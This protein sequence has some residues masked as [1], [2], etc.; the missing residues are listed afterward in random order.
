MSRNLLILGNG[1]DLAFGYRTSYSDFATVGFSRYCTELLGTDFWPFNGS[2]SKIFTEETLFSHFKN[3]KDT[4]ISADGSVGWI[5]LESELLNYAKSKSRS[6][7]S[8]ELIAYDKACFEWLRNNLWYF[9]RR[10]VPHERKRDFQIHPSVLRLFEAIRTNGRFNKVITFNYS[11]P[12]YTLNQFCS[13]END[14]MPDV[15]YIHGNVGGASPSDSNI[16]IGI[17]EDHDI[18]REYRFLYK[19]TQVQPHSFTKNLQESDT[20]IIYGL[21][22]G[23]IDREYFEP[24]F[25]D[26]IKSE[27]KHQNKRLV[28]VTKNIESRQSIIDNIIDMGFR[29]RDLNERLE[30]IF[31]K[32]DDLSDDLND[33]F[34]TSF[35]DDLAMK[36]DTNPYIGTVE[37]PQ[38]FNF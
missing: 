2:P 31:F 16:I 37:I 7:K 34:F 27:F 8:V 30:I 29:W 3:Y 6:P 38:E 32:M 19:S 9:I 25:T 20:I 15:T 22:M 5:D 1:F 13:Y 11:D 28:F 23:I 10:M 35:I 18:A 33:N 14:K 17:N 36:P 12:T 26:L 24:Y 21:A 4:K